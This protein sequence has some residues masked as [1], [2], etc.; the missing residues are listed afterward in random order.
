MRYKY[1]I[2]VLLLALAVVA[3]VV[4]DNEY[5]T[6]VLV[7]TYIF[8]I[9]ALSYDLVIGGMGQISLG[10]QAFLGVGAYVSAILSSK[11][12][13][14]VWLCL[15]A[16]VFAA[17]AVG[18]FIGCVSLRIRGAYLAIVTLGF[19]MILWM[20]AMGWRAVTN[21]QMG[22]R[23]IP[24]L[25]IGLPFL[26]R[27]EFDSPG[28]YYYLALVFLLFTIYFISRLM[29]SRLGMAITALRE[30]EDRSAI[31][32]I[33]AFVHFL[34]AFTIS[35]ALAGFAGFAYVHYIA[36]VDPKILSQYYMITGLIMV[37]VGGTTTIGGPIVG[38]LIFF[39][40][41]EWL[42]IAQEARL[43]LFGAMLLIFNTLMPQG[44]YP[45]SLALRRFVLER[46]WRRQQ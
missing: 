42:R 19:A 40:L 26:P 17:G 20:I 37:I 36:F 8:A 44:I 4:V 14:P 16:A 12:G 11:L 25:V 22:I 31:L 2:F 6:H 27:I 45:A 5:F 39:F 46:G 34:S 23:E 24:P 41:P 18:L 15:F 43:I 33:G 35:A 3:P 38:A 32:G 21:G 28:K 13:V 29:K 7:L 9:F 30:N 10:Q 1:V